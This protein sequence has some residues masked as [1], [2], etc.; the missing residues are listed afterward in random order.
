L[1]GGVEIGAN[2]YRISADG[3]DVILDCGMHPKKEGRECLPNF[4]LLNRPPQALIVSHAHHDH[5][6]AVPY[7]MRE[8]DE[9]VCYSTK[10]TVRIM[11]RMLH[12]SVSVMTM[13]S[14]ERGLKDYP[15]YRHNDVERAMERTVGFDLQKE[16]ALSYKCPFRA[17]FWHSGHV[18]GSASV[19][20]KTDGHTFYYTG[21]VCA[22]NQ[23]L[24]GGLTP[25]NADINVDTLIIE[26]TRGAYVDDEYSDYESEIKRFGTAVAD[27]VKGG[28]VALVP[29]FALGRMQE[30]LNVINRLQEEGV[31]PDCPVFASGLGRAVYEVYS[32]YPEYLRADKELVPLLQFEGIGDVWSPKV[33][34]SL[35]KTPG[36]IVATSGM[37]VENTPS[38]MIAMDMVKEDRHGI[39]F[40]GY[41]DPDTLGHKVLCAQPGDVLAFTTDGQASEISLANIQ[42]FHF[43]AHAPREDLRNVV[44]H[45]KPKNIIFVHGDPDAMEWMKENSPDGYNKFIPETGETVQLES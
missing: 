40:A 30:L 34:R 39:L 13:M 26:T 25:L 36:I 15:L 31:V 7:L 8:F 3:H 23:E 18:L 6:G 29:A 10:P 4:E 33:R 22:T 44:D 45:V 14:K 35:L 41:L 32:R 17:E 19:L 5:C 43:S 11:D 1:G 27:I 2:C 9:L 24:M 20:L 12:N 38:A 28:G 42:R 16:F 37:M 21:D